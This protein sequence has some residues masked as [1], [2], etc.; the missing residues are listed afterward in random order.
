[1]TGHPPDTPS[2]ELFPKNSNKSWVFKALPYPEPSL[3]LSSV[4]SVKPLS[5]YSLWPSCNLHVDVG[6]VRVP[7]T[8]NTHWVLLL[9]VLGVPGRGGSLIPFWSHTFYGAG[10]DL[11]F[12]IFLPLPQGSASFSI[13]LQGL[14]R[15]DFPTEKASAGVLPR[16]S[17][18]CPAFLMP[19]LVSLQRG[20]TSNH[21]N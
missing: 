7:R 10:D 5:L 12:L 19:L 15:S 8:P 9:C 2:K 13:G 6:S 16:L 3:T 21:L 4:A 20:D 11:E 14:P 17:S 18:L 1:M